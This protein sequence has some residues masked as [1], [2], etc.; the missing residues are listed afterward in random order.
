MAIRARAGDP[1]SDQETTVLGLVADGLSDR[2]VGDKLSIALDTVKTHL[3]RIYQKLG[4]TGRAH[5]VSLA[6][7]RDGGAT[8]Q[9]ARARKVLAKYR[10]VRQNAPANSR[11]A[12]FYDELAQTVK[13]E[14]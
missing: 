9:L 12:A 8:A 10:G 2:Q 6:F 11:F 4:A 3:R 13:D 14:L 1:L 7:G 5:A